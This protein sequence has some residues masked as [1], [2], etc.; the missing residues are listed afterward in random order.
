MAARVRFFC[1]V[2][3]ASL[4]ALGGLARLT[5][6]SGQLEQARRYH[7]QAL[8]H[9]EA[10]GYVAGTATSLANLGSL[11]VRPIQARTG[12]AA[13]MLLLSA[14]KGG[15]SPLTLSNP[16]ILHMGD[17]HESDADSYTESIRGVLRDGLRLI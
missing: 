7:E 12:R 13:Q 16:L 2:L 10:I 8:E 6:A 1:A 5:A 3:S 14:Q 11:V 4:A 17:R 15:K 9:N